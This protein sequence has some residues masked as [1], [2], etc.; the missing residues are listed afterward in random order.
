MLKG[1][2]SWSL[3]KSG[4]WGRAEL[5]LLFYVTLIT[6]EPGCP[7]ASEAALGSYTASALENARC[8]ASTCRNTSAPGA[9]NGHRS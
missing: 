3:E 2:F 8:I 5:H 6:V 4:V 7:A 9:E 1:T